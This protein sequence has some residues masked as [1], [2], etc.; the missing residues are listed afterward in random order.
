MLLFERMT[1]VVI[2]IALVRQVFCSSTGK[3]NFVAYSLSVRH[4]FGVFCLFRADLKFFSCIA[5]DSSD[6]RLSCVFGSL[7]EQ[8]SLQL[9][10]FHSVPLLEEHPETAASQQ[11]Q[12]EAKP[13]N[14][15]V[16]F[17]FTAKD[18]VFLSSVGCC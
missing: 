3:L 16:T 1:P 4:S 11:L 2:C 6:L 18:L 7:E 15:I 17:T 14:I 12:S 5:E 13:V 9:V 10:R 8:V